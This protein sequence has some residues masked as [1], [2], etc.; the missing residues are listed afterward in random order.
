MRGPFTLNCVKLKQVTKPRK[1]YYK[2]TQTDLTQT[3]PVLG[4]FVL[5]CKAKAVSEN[6]DM[7]SANRCGRMFRTCWV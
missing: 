7:T 1:E 3:L 5:M 2:V 6:C 4:L